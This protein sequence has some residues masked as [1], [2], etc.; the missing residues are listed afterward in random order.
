M[1]GKPA[2]LPIPTAVE[3]DRR[4]AGLVQTAE[5][6]FET[7][8]DAVERVRHHTRLR[9]DQLRLPALAIGG[10]RRLDGAG[11]APLDA[12]PEAVAA[13]HEMGHDVTGLPGRAVG[14]TGPGRWRERPD[15]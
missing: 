4:E 11:Q 1:G 13:G 14:R 7:V 12:L 9:T 5:Q 2:G 10:G 8:G 3:G 6:P 15:L